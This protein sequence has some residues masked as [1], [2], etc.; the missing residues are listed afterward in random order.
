M[1]NPLLSD[2]WPAPAPP[3]PPKKGPPK[4]RHGL[5]LTVAYVTC[6]IKPRF[7]WF[8]NS[9]A[10]EIRMTPG[11]RPEN[12]QILVVDS[13]LWYDD[14]RQKEFVDIAAGKIAFE[15]RPP[16]PSPWQGPQRQTSKD[17]FCAVN[18]R[19]SA[20][21]YTRANHVAFADDVGVLL[22]GWLRAHL[23]A[24]D[25]SYALVGTTCKV[26]NLNVNEEGEVTSYKMAPDGQ[27]SRI[28]QI[29]QPLQ[30]C[31]GLWLYGGTF[32][33]PMKYALAV[34]GKDE[35]Y[36]GINGADYDFGLRLERAGA[37]FYITRSCGRYESR[38][39]VEP[40]A[41]HCNK[42]WAGPDGPHVNHYLINDLKRTPRSWTRGNDYVLRDVRA[43]VLEVGEAGFPPVKPGVR[44]WVDK[45]LLSE[46]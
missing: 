4:N 44:H 23:G 35:C 43:R 2:F 22:P 37:P 1:T 14:Q 5:V 6:R 46:M 38:D 16:R 10:R 11:L 9:L 30:K 26:H 27:D 28:S 12:V 33:V 20:L 45:Q 25:S 40:R 31:T 7:D 24:V 17:Y 29:T 13:R 34:N 8:C 15:H 39:D 3:P 32:S 36:M 42:P 18:A 21:A 41:L 19:N